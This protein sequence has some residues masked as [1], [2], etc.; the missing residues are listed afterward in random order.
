MPMALCLAERQRN[1]RGLAMRLHRIELAGFNPLGAESLKAMG[2]MS[3]I[4]S[5]RLSLFV[6]TRGDGPAILARLLE[7]FPIS[8]V[9]ARTA[10][11][12]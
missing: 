12:V 11:A 10:G 1:Q 5:W 9:E 8:R 3:G 2:L 7:R 4:I 6:P